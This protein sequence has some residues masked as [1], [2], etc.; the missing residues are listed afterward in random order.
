M[1]PY[2]LAE[3]LKDAGFPQ[4]FSHGDKSISLEG[5]ADFDEHTHDYLRNQEVKLPTLSEFIEACGEE[6]FSLTR[7]GNTW[8][9]NFIEGASGDSAGS[10]PDE[11]VARL[12]LGFNKK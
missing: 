11:A 3:K 2:E 10:T 4:T 8:L 9:T 7:H 1:I 12:W 5:I 6:L